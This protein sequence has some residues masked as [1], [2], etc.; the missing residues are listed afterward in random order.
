MA[1][2]AISP[3]PHNF[4]NMAARRVPLG[5]VPNAANSP[6]RQGHVLKR[7]RDQANAQEN[8]AYDIQPLA[9]RQAIDSFHTR[10]RPSP[11]KQTSQ[12][13]DERGFARPGNHVPPSAFERRLLAARENGTPRPSSTQ[14]RVHRQEKVTQE[15]ENLEEVRMWQKHYKKAFPQFI[16][17]FEGLPEDVRQR[18]LKTVRALGA[19][20]PPQCTVHLTC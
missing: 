8:F 16:F 2:L 14:Q 4:S 18:C 17:Y 11:A 7:S 20:S 1:T 15:K 6:A 12:P 9:K 13:K 10:T 19:V 5:D 3:I